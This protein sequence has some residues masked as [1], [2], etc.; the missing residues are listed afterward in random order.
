MAGVE[1][2]A[3]DVSGGRQGFRDGQCAWREKGI[4]LQ[5]RKTC[6]LFRNSRAEPLVMAAPSSST[7]S[8]FTPAL[9][10]PPTTET[11]QACVQGP[12]RWHAADA[13]PR[14]APAAARTAPQ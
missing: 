9:T 14:P 6:G 3:G 5:A 4:L 10:T 2:A 7:S 13:P 8:S 12:P 11:H 1:P